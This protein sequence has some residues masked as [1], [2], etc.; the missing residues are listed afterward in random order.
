MKTSE[1]I[2]L[3]GSCSGAILSI[4]ALIT[5]FVKPLRSKFVGWI[6]KLTN[7]KELDSKID[8]LT[9]LVEKQVELNEKLRTTLDS[10]SEALRCCLR[11]SILATYYKYHTAEA[12]PL[13]EKECFTKNCETYFSMGGNSFVHSCY[14]EIMTKPTI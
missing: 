11:T 10:Q 4:I 14:D 13:L 5:T 1:I 12:I 2:Q 6:F 7:R 9:N 3:L 8:T